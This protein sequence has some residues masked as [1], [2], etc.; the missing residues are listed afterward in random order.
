MQLDA[1]CVRFDSQVMAPY[2]SGRILESQSLK[3]RDAVLK[4]FFSSKIANVTLS[5]VLLATI[6][7]MLRFFYPDSKTSG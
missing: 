6:H 4:Q 3:D 7:L 2:R 5:Y 1:K